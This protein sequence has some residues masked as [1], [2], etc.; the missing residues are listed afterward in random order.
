L[1][2]RG[3][4]ALTALVKNTPVRA[5]DYPDTATALSLVETLWGENT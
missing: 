4:T 3:F 1:G 5:I 2:E